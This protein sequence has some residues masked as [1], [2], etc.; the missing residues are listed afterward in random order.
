MAEYDL[1]AATQAPIFA[2]AG[3]TAIPQNIKW[4]VLGIVNRALA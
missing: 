1:G 3:K 4:L 2:L